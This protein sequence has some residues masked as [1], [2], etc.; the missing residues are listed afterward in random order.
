[1][2]DKQQR[3][4]ALMRS[5]WSN[6]ATAIKSDDVPESH[7]GNPPNP[8][9]GIA[10]G[11]HRRLIREGETAFLL[12]DSGFWLQ[13]APH[14]RSMIEHS[15]FLQWLNRDGPAVLETLNLDFSRGFG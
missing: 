14:R 8:V 12:S 3:R 13:A 4:T 7:Q 2:G 5:L 1:M 10:Y 11:W 9:Y 6:L 15:A